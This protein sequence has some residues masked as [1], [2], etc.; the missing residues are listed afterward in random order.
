MTVGRWL[1]R[2]G[3]WR[4]FVIAVLFASGVLVAGGVALADDPGDTA[5]TT[6]TE[7]TTTTTSDAT[8]APR[9]ALTPLDPTAATIVPVC[10]DGDGSEPL[11]FNCSLFTQV[12]D[13]RYFQV[14]GTGLVTVHF[15]YVLKFGACSNQLAVFK[16][17]DRSGSINGV[18]PGQPS[19][20]SEVA[21]RAQVV[22]GSGSSPF[23]PDVDL[24]FQGGD[25]LGLRFT[26]CGVFYYSYEQA[27]PDGFDHLLAFQHILG[28]PWQFAW[29]D[30]F[31]GGDRDFD[32]TV[33]NIGG[34]AS[35]GGFK[36]PP[37]TFVALG[38][39]YSSGEGNPPFFAGTDGPHDYCHRS[40]AAYPEVLGARFN[41]LPLFYAC[42]GATTWNITQVPKDTEPPQIDEPGIDA[43][44]RLLTVTIGG[45]NA[46]FSSVLKACIEQKLK[47]DFYNNN[48]S[49]V[50]NLFGL[51]MDPSC[52]HSDK[53]TSS[54][55]TAIDNIFWP[56]KLTERDILLHVDPEK[57][58]IIT[59]DYPHLFPDG[60]S[61][62]LSLK[63]I[64]TIDDQTWLNDEG[65]HLDG[66]LQQAAGEAGV[67]FVDV[68]DTFAGHEVC[69]DQGDYL[70]GLSTA[71]GNG[72][73]CTWKVLGHCII[74]GIPIIGSFHPNADG[75]EFGYAAAIGSYIDSAT[76]R[77]PSGFPANPPP[78]PDPPSTPVPPAIGL[79][80]LT[81]L[82]VTAGSA[83]CDGTYQ[84]GQQAHLTGGG[85]VPG[86]SIDVYVSSAGLPPSGQLLLTTLTADSAGYV[87]AVVRVPL[88]ASGFVPDGAAA[89]VVFFD[90]IGAG[91]SADTQDDIAMAGLAPHESSCGTVEQLPFDGFMPP[92][93]NLPNANSVKPGQAV[94]VKFSIPGS[95]GTVGDVLVGGYPQ[96]T[97]V[98]CTSPDAPTSGDPTVS[99]SNGAP[100][101]ADQY[102][103]VWKTDSGWRGCRMLIL[104]LVDGS[105]HRALFNFGS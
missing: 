64:L 49:P 40:S 51:G 92:V 13:R 103:Y 5:T 75:H 21:S 81:V 102:N 10:G 66:V 52:A 41:S 18:L 28:Q 44:T 20:P 69:G 79:G 47:A 82:P 80:D 89:G 85:F 2:G 32:D 101:P 78:L 46:G 39:S 59:A 16:V 86:S 93:A 67:N 36:L 42:S 38:D 50:G 17:D 7:A 58:S 56:V 24:T 62:C 31:F 70:N 34:P 87:D 76:I 83:D 61:D 30:L 97:P 55:H 77:T 1:R 9:A 11:A 96:S 73:S 90:V 60:G 99:A 35:G 84:S 104:K 63:I 45:N 71:S 3:M 26:G 88:S 57:A 27:N 91:S 68:R 6:T 8:D 43:S 95:N 29:E 14:P 72:G 65:D 25:L 98:S 33:I 23:S 54:V 100:P 74:P 105:Y 94:P 19:W 4:I 53:F 15:D 12:V 48:I 22:F 37:D